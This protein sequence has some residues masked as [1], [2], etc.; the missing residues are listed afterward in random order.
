MLLYCV[1][2]LMN[3]KGKSTIYLGCYSADPYPWI[4]DMFTHR[5]ND[6]LTMGQKYNVKKCAHLNL[7]KS[8][9]EHLVRFFLVIWCTYYQICK[10]HG[11]QLPE[12]MGMG[13]GYR[14]SSIPLL[15][16]HIYM[17]QC[18]LTGNYQKNI[19]LMVWIFHPY[20]MPIQPLIHPSFG[21]NHMSW[22][23]VTL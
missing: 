2:F 1:C 5:K 23:L 12:S 11:S 13:Q 20:T 3:Y 6:L 9:H 19:D 14:E 10:N 15:V 16:H 17:L 22:M 8:N 7:Q 21:D 18:D 4:W